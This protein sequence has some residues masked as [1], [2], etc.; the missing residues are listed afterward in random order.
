MIESKSTATA[1]TDD[2]QAIHNTVMAVEETWNQHDM[3][4]FAALLTDDVEWVNGVG[5]W[6]RGKAG[7]KRGHQAYHESFFKET[8]RHTESITIQRLT[9]DVAIVTTM[10]RMGDWTR[11]D[12]GRLITNGRDCMT[13]VLVKQQGHWLI[14]RGHVSD[15]DP[16]AAPFDPVNRGEHI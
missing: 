9:P 4:A 5:M 8:G 15:I 2:E 3:D 10:N 7:V 11:P 12:D 6:W 1:L 16:K 14:C 13:Y